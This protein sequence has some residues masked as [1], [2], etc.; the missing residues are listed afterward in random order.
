LITIK[1]TATL[2]EACQL[3]VNGVPGGVHRICV[4]NEEG[5]ITGLVTQSAVVAY[6]AK[7]DLLKHKKDKS[8]EQLQLGLKPILSISYK[9]RA[10]NGFRKLHKEKVSGLAIID[11][12]S[13]IFSNLSGKDLRVIRGKDPLFKDS[14]DYQFNRLMLPI[15]EFL[16]IERMNDIN[17]RSPIFSCGTNETLCSCLSKIISLK[18][19]RI[20][21]RDE[22][23]F[24]AGV[25]SL[26]DIINE[27]IN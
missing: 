20:Y 5:Q 16:S 17:A 19:H 26:R 27:L 2:F 12:D 4:V 3:L 11:D 8:L 1:P 9:E 25:I 10:I 7:Q 21:I 14:H 24:P 23:S 6:I 15:H 22:K 13:K 18:V